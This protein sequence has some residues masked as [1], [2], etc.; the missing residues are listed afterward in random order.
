MKHECIIT[1]QS[2]QVNMKWS[3]SSST[4]PQK[5]KYRFIRKMMTIFFTGNILLEILTVQR[6]IIVQYIYYIT[7]H[8]NDFTRQNKACNLFQEDSFPVFLLFPSG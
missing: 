5:A 2:K 7:D 1:P 3:Y 8:S 6:T 4:L